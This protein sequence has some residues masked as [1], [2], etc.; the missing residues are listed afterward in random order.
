MPFNLSRRVVQCHD[1]VPATNRPQRTHAL[2]RS[3]QIL[4]RL[5]ALV[6]VGPLQCSGLSFANV[7]FLS[8]AYGPRHVVLHLFSLSHWVSQ[9]FCPH[10]LSN[11]LCEVPLQLRSARAQLRSCLTQPGPRQQGP[12]KARVVGFEELLQLAVLCLNFLVPE[13]PASPGSGGGAPARDAK[14]FE[15]QSC[16]NE[17]S[18]R[19]DADSS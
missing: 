18:I 17:D 13:S 11:S 8:F 1:P 10:L 3:P 6:Q 14:P 5:G 19:G 2:N 4:P 12:K 16:T 15:S 9:S 7:P